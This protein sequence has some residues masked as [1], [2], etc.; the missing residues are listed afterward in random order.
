MANEFLVSV[1]DAIGRNPS[2]GALLFVGKANISSSFTMSTQKT[3]V[4]GGIGN[5]VVY[6]Y[7]HDKAVEVSIESATFEK[8][9]LAINAGASIV[10]ETVEVVKQEAVT[11]VGGEGTLSETPV[12]D[13]VGILFN[14]GAIQNV[15]P[16]GTSITVSGGGSETV[17]AVYT[18]E[19]VADSITGS[20][21]EPPTGVDLTLISEVRNSSTALIYYFV[22]NIPNFNVSGNYTMSLAANGVSQQTLDGMAA[23]TTAPT[24]DYYFKCAWVAAAGASTVGYT[25]IAATPSII[26]FDSTSLPATRQLTV[27]GIRGGVYSNV[28]ITSLC[29]YERTSGCAAITAGSASG[30]ITAGSGALLGDSAVITASYWDSTSGSLTDTMNVLVS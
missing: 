19:V 27:L 9:I 26:T 23:V 24:G 29:A 11:L 16:S 14:S 25:D 13:T 8:S 30:I 3:E 18:Y 28:N 5:P 7:Y 10:N 12:S 17:T 6:T 4:R 15:A 20:S 21:T 22:V 2:T 1:A